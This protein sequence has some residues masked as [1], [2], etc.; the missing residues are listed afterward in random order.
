MPKLKKHF[1]MYNLDSML[2]SLKWYFIVFVERLPFS[3]CLRIWDIYLL[4]GERVITAMAYTILRLHKNKILKLKDMDLIVEY[5]QVKLYKD[6]GYDDD[7]VIKSLEQSMESLRKSNLESPP[8][9][10]E[11]EFPKK[12]FGKFVEPSFEAKIGRRKPEFT[13]TEKDVTT[14]VILQ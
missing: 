2:Y 12:P 4:H 10:T 1:D 11:S 8:P 3:L 5:I 13:K 7:F 14:N 6:F 9:P